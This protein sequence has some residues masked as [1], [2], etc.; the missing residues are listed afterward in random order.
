VMDSQ[1]LVHEDLRHWL[2]V[3]GRF[4]NSTLRARGLVENRRLLIQLH[5]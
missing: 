4:V 3:N 2:L 1:L 5:A